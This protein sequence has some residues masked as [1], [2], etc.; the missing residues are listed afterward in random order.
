VEPTERAA[1]LLVDLMGQFHD[2]VL[3]AVF[4]TEDL[5]ADEAF[6][7]KLAGLLGSCN[8]P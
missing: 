1:R 7:R 5:I 6:I 8:R 4:E 3:S 2:A